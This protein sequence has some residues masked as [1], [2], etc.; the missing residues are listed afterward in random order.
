MYVGVDVKIFLEYT[1][2][3]Y[4]TLTIL[5]YKDAHT[6]RMKELHAMAK[7]TATTTSLITIYHAY[8]THTHR[9]RR[10]SITVRA[11]QNGCMPLLCSA[12]HKCASTAAVFATV[13]PVFGVAAMAWNTD[14][15]W[16][17]RS[18]AAGGAA[19]VT[20]KFVAV[21]SLVDVHRLFIGRRRWCTHLHFANT[22]KWTICVIHRLFFFFAAPSAISHMECYWRQVIY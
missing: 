9:H 6:T 12:M 22:V 5:T 2:P 19:G 11:I 4:I 10:L 1:R 21:F 8:C 17:S 14:V 16:C 7:A 20:S 15:D 3:L 13:H 18:A